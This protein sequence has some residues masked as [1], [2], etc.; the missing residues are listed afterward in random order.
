M[1]VVEGSDGDAVL[2]GLV[3]NGVYYLTPD[4]PLG[5][6]AF[7]GDTA[8]PVDADSNT[9]ENFQL[10]AV[11]EREHLLCAVI[12]FDDKLFIVFRGT[13]SRDDWTKT[14]LHLS[15][16]PF[17]TTGCFVHEGFIRGYFSSTLGEDK[18]YKESLHQGLM[19]AIEPHLASGYQVILTG[20]SLGGALATVR[21]RTRDITR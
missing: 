4:F 5:G 3:S 19:K 13:I 14:N 1:P 9:E 2:A 15:R 18:G 20:H 8:H 17:L 6:V 21:D 11:L 16:V 10:V 12:V 7:I